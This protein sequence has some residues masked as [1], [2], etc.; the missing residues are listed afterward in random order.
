MATTRTNTI[1]LTKIEATDSEIAAL[2][3][4]LEHFKNVRIF[5]VQRVVE[6][7]IVGH[8]NYVL[9]EVVTNCDSADPGID[10]LIVGHLLKIGPGGIVD[11][12]PRVLWE[13]QLWRIIK[14]D[15]VW[16]TINCDLGQRLLD[17]RYTNGI[18]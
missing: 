12:E 2:G 1:R 13:D 11:Q 6:S 14:D 7:G 10:P 18:I 16:D 15:D 8:F 9:V 17:L 3:L 4:D 5:D